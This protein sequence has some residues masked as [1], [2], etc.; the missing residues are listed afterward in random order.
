[1]PLSRAFGRERCAE[2]STIQRTLNAI[3]EENVAQL[4]QAVDGLHRTNSPIISHLIEKEMLFL[5]VDLTGL[6]AS[7]GAELS[8][9]GYFS[10]GRGAT[11]RQLLRVVAPKYGEVLF[12]KLYAGNTN[13][14][15][16]LKEAMS[17]AERLLGLDEKKRKRILVRLDRGF[18]TDE[19]LEW[20]IWRG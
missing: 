3:S 10:G 6:R 16:V 2:Q 12:E 5:E 7:K 14:C 15:E 1:M 9:K 20:L 8:T 4:R 11:G 13:S 18:G 17:E 19:N